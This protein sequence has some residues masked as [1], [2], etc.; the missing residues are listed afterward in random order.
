MMRTMLGFD[1]EAESSAAMAV[2]QS[3]III[4]AKAL[5][6]KFVRKLVGVIVRVIV[7]VIV[8]ISCG[9]LYFNRTLLDWANY[10]INNRTRFDATVSSGFAIMANQSKQRTN[11]QK[12][13][14][15][16]VNFAKYSNKGSVSEIIK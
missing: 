11:I 15:I 14:Q 13:N 16:N 12:H 8:C 7:V 6:K 3:V 1:S 2:E 10:D 5:R 9:N 4:A